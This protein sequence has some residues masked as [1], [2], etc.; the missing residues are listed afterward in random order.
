[1][2]VQR[3]RGL[4]AP[5]A[6]RPPVQAP[7]VADVPAAPVGGVPLPSPSSQSS[8][9]QPSSPLPLAPLLGGVAGR[10]AP[11]DSDSDALP[12]T[13]MET[14]PDL[15][16][17]AAQRL[18]APPLIGTGNFPVTGLL[19]QRTPPP[20]LSPVQ[21]RSIDTPR[22][23][24][25]VDLRMADAHGS[26]RV[27]PPASPG[28]LVPLAATPPGAVPRSTAVAQRAPASSVSRPSDPSP[29]TPVQRQVAPM[30]PAGPLPLLT[31]SPAFA[32]PFAGGPAAL[33]APAAIPA[34]L[35]APPSLPVELPA[36]PAVPAGLP[37]VDGALAVATGAAG[38]AG[39][40]LATGDL[41]ALAGRLY[42]KIRYRLKAELRLDRERA[43]LI[44]DRR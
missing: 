2:A 29:L 38:A 36:V 23:A 24:V 33:A 12:P 35:P 16:L 22:P 43:G 44:T 19:P 11:T 25:P 4:G 9:P 5:L 10:E 37:G 27:P 8:G 31:P 39:G 6:E 17:V 32:A 1:L 18:A 41:D 34:D 42:D 28:P 40:A 7:I 15:P 13:P 30:E 21:R 3:R 20:I 26:D 14:G